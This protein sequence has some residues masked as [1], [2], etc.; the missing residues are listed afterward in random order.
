MIQPDNFLYCITLF[1]LGIIGATYLLFTHYVN[2]LLVM[3]AIILVLAALRVASE[4]YLQQIEA[5]DQVQQYVP[6]HLLTLHVL[7][8]LQWVVIL[9]YVNPFKKLGYGKYFTA[10]FAYVLFIG[11]Q[12]I[13]SYYYYVDPQYFFY[14]PERID[15]YW[16]F[17]ANTDLWYVAF[18]DTMN[19]VSLLIVALILIAGVVQNSSNRLRQ[20]IIVLSYLI[21]PFVYFAMNQGGGVW[22][23][24]NVGGLFLL[25]GTLISWYVSN[26]RLFKGSLGLITK[27]LFESISDLTISTDAK[28]K[29][30]EYNRITSSL[31]RTEGKT[32]VDLLGQ[33]AS[34]GKS[35]IQLAIDQLLKEEKQE[36]EL[37]LTDRNGQ[38]RIFNL[39]VAPFKSGDDLLG[40][41]FL[42]TDLTDIRAKE[43]ELASLNR[44]K[45][46]LFAI[47]GHDL[48]RPALEFRGIGSKV[49]Y[50]IQKNDYPNLLKYGETLEKAAF[51]LNSLLD[52]LLNWALQQRNVMPYQ[53]RAI[54]VAEEVADIYDQ[55]QE[56]AQKKNIK[57]QF[58][59]PAEGEIYAD[60]N[61]F[62]TIVRNLVDNAIKF[63]SANGQVQLTQEIVGQEV[64][65]KII[66]T[67]IG[68]PPAELDDLFQLK[69][70]RSR[71]GTANEKGTGLGLNLVNELVKLNH[72]RI[73]VESKVGSGTTFTVFFSSQT[74]L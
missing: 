21:L 51:S 6:W 23:V 47:I 35:T 2:R 62:L 55:F 1:S 59:L 69:E 70:K 73:T 9:L 57:L 16:Q 49:N 5:F 27:D 3:N 14:N 34:N 50:L 13:H 63:T 67:G 45:D 44:T 54:K 48:R 74:A 24:P 4:Y 60:L 66:D 38:D 29:V 58:D 46:S 71:P 10:F 31:L 40:Y 39:K 56:F 20:S 53:P 52:N 7:A 22:N 41:T 68:I 64:A 61:S 17:R 37:L 19:K 36:H 8:P 12:L 72:G 65:L 42:L 26:Y 28:L 43:K 18:G 32:V 15:G 11:G 30:V 25:H 33:H